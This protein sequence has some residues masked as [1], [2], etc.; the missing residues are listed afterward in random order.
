MQVGVGAPLVGVAVAGGPAPTRDATAL[1]PP[2]AH[3]ARD[4]HAPPEVVRHDAVDERV[5]CALDVRQGHDD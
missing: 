5:G 1:P 2:A 3:P 4:A